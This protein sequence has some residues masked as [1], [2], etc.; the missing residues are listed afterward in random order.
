MIYGGKF[1]VL[2]GNS[3][4]FLGLYQNLK[5]WTINIPLKLSPLL[6]VFSHN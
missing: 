4:N 6:S 2:L 1:F 3:N 5:K